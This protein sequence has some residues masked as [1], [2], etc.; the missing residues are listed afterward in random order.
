MPGLVDE[1]EHIL[2]WIRDEISPDTYVNI[3]V[4]SLARGATAYCWAAGSRLSVLQ[5]WICD[6]IWTQEQ[7]RPTHI[8]GKGE[9]RS[10]QQGLEKY[11]EIDR[12]VSQEEV[13]QVREYARSIG[14]WRFEEPPQH[15]TAAVAA[16]TDQRH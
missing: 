3:M 12:A 16:A 10:R 5:I 6:L 14:L 8:V 2:R 9:R 11:P 13:R 7:Y 4:S 15:E 1:A